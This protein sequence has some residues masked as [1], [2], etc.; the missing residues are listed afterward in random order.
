MRLFI[1]LAIVVMLF[2][3]VGNIERNIPESN[4]WFVNNMGYKFIAQIDVLTPE[5]EAQLVVPK[6]TQIKK[7]QRMCE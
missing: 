3:S 4:A 7:L 6:C 1:T 2:G 5:Q